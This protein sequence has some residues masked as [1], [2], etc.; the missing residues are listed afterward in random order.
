MDSSIPDFQSLS[1]S[2]KRTRRLRHE[3]I[4][5][6][7]RYRDH[8]GDIQ[9]DP[10][11]S[12]RDCRWQNEDGTLRCNDERAL[13]FDHKEGKGSAE[14]KTG[15]IGGNRLYYEIRKHP[16]RFQLLCANCNEIKAKGEKMGARLHKKPQRVRL[17]QQI[18]GQTPRRVREK[19]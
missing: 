14:R 1:E 15:K 17:S 3:C 19:W 10:R 16:E 2:G 4:E 9:N 8:N 18:A 13:Q 7:G 11:C 5:I 12:N 6:L